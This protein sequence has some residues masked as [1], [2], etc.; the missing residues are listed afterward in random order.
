MKNYIWGLLGVSLLAIFAAFLMVSQTTKTVNYLDGLD[1][2]ANVLGMP[3][4]LGVTGAS[5]Y[6][7]T[8]GSDS[9]PGTAD[10]PFLTIQ[11]GVDVAVAGDTIIVKNGTYNGNCS[12]QSF[13][14]VIAK[15]GTISAP[16]TIKAENK[17]GAILDSQNICHSYIVFMDGAAYITI[18][19]F[20]IRRGYWGGIWANSTA[21]HITIKNNEIKQTGN[22]R[23]ETTGIGMVGI[24]TGNNNNNFRIEG[25][26]IHDIGRIPCTAATYPPPS[27]N[28]TCNND[29]HDHGIYFHGNNHVIVN[30][31]FYAPFS[32]WAITV[33]GPNDNALIANN[34]FIGAAG[35]NRDGQIVPGD[36]SV[37]NLKIRNNIFYNPKTAA[38]SNCV[39][40]YSGSST[41]SDNFIYSPTFT[42]GTASI[43][44]D[45][46]CGGSTGVNTITQQ[47]NH[48]NVNPRLENATSIPYDINIQSVSPV[49][50]TGTVLSEVLNDF[51]GAVRP[52]GTAYDIGAVEYVVEATDTQA[53]STPTDLTATAISSSQINLSWGASTDNINVAGYHI[54]RNGVQITT[55]TG[56]TYQNN[57][58]T[59]STS[60]SYTVQS[61][62]AAGNNSTQ[63]SPVNVITLPI[64]ILQ[65]PYPGPNPVN[66]P[67]QIEAEN[68][69]KGGEGVSYHDTEV[70]NWGGIYRYEGV[71]VE[72]TT[73]VGGGYNLGY[74]ENGEW[75]EYTV[76]VATA[77]TY[78]IEFRIAGTIPATAHVEF[79]GVD[80]TGLLNFPS[81]GGWQTWS[82]VTKT[83]VYLSAGIQVMRFYYD[84]AATN[85]NWIRVVVPQDTQAP[86]ISSIGT[87]NI[88]Q[89]STM[90]TWA[91]NE[92]STTFV[93]YGL[94]SS[95]T[96]TIGDSNLSTNHAVVIL[97]L[98]PSTPYHFRV[99]SSDVASNQ[100]VSSDRTFTTQ[101]LSGDIAPAAINSLSRSLV[102]SRTSAKLMWISPGSDGN[103]G[104]ASFYDIRYSKS[105]IMEDNWK[106]ATQVSG[107]PKPALAG[108]NQNYTV[109]GLSPATIYYFA[110]KTSD[111]TGNISPLSNVITFV[112]SKKG[113]W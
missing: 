58:L 55:I 41:F 28:G 60:Y 97:N 25:N 78:N 64:T 99:K 27:G 46:V 98:F 33:T 9:N 77:G 85:L 105:P 40:S 102:S 103:V 37:S 22:T 104:T 108:T 1:N 94:S 12:G 96:S 110:I 21:H 32:G 74:I 44:N 92:P 69:D 83:G 111:S 3:K 52:Q 81:T 5:Y 4:V 23:L 51:N 70:N 26:V 106:N 8:T 71:D 95:Y 80:K 11:R 17:W 24:Y 61:Y 15:T 14:V 84:S 6:V 67:G 76:N 68:F 45:T 19:G 93:D 90:V 50:D 53:P 88:S 39:V 79:N 10:A 65:T 7:S 72:S 38:I 82:T 49:I 36:G 56:T 20:I 47:N 43:Y 2:S 57:G 31:L 109:S 34:T 101:S 89:N 18:D 62:D 63:S 42:Y 100:T 48:Y 66:L 113:W 75:V 91:T 30:N 59:P 16:I 29:W 112:T 86:V 54:F 13:P 73:D 87:S 35:A 107:E